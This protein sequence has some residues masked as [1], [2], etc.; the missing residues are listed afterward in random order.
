MRTILLGVDGE[1]S[2]LAVEESDR[3]EVQLPKTKL[4]HKPTT[5]SNEIINAQCCLILVNFRRTSFSGALAA[6]S[7]RDLVDTGSI[8]S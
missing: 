3:D 7:Y 5:N 2:T 8:Y 1:L 4:K 6:K